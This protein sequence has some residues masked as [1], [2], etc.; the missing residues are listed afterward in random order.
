MKKSIIALL[1]ALS[2][3]AGSDAFASRARLLVTGTGDAGMIL[4]GAGGS[5]YTEDAY[6]MF[7]N[8]SYVNDYKDWGIIERSQTGAVADNPFGGFVTSMMNTNVGVFFNRTTYLPTFSTATRAA[9]RPIELMVGGDHGVKW[10]L[11][12]AYARAGTVQGV[13]QDLTLRLGAQFDGF[14][15]FLTYKIMGKEKAG[16]ADNK[17]KDMMAGFRYHWGEW[18]PYAAYRQTK[19]NGNTQANSW[20]L[21]MG[22]N[23]KVAE[24]VKLNY[25]F[26]FWRT[27]KRTGQSVVPIDLS[28][29]GDATSWLTL[30]AGLNYRLYDQI[31][32]TTQT[33]ASTGRLGATFKWNKLSMDWAVGTGAGVGAEAL[34]APTF[35]FDSQFFAATSLQYSW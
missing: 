6:N 7:Y 27:G 33:D 13:S 32:K 19:T 17:F 2:F 24:G 4:D 8:P 18:V 35:G 30:R 11:G 29:E 26:G 14:D 20:G 12:L 25:G 3:T 22:R 9:M 16:T 34:D 10:G 21:G 23:T 28:V 31:A 15:P 5:F 1:L